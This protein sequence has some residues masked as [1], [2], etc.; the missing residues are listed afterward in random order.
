MDN[1]KVGRFFWDTVYKSILSHKLKT[2]IY[3]KVK[4][5]RN[6]YR[7]EDITAITVI[8][9][10]ENCIPQ[11]VSTLCPLHD[12]YHR[13]ENVRL[14]EIQDLGTDD[15]MTVPASSMLNTSDL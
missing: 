9:S 13:T 6:L 5:Y 10:T 8:Y 15:Q 7:R 4:N 3:L 12:L 14:V 11:V 2:Q 1:H